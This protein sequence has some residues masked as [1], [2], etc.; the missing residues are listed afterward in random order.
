MRKDLRQQGL[1]RENA[2]LLP[3]GARKPTEKEIG[4]GE[5]VA[6][7]AGGLSWREVH[8]FCPRHR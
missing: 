6:A 5:N 2:R 8:S 1:E 3:V 7:G 4:E